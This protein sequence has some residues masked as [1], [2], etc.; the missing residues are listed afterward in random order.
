L[1]RE[2][3][4]NAF[5]KGF[6]GPFFPPLTEHLTKAW[7]DIN[8]VS[9]SLGTARR[10]L[11][12]IG[13]SIPGFQSRLEIDGKDGKGNFVTRWNDALLFT[14]GK[15]EVIIA[16]HWPKTVGE[17][18]VNRTEIPEAGVAVYKL[19][20]GNEVKQAIV[21]ECVAIYTK[22]EVSDSD[23][24]LIIERL[25]LRLTIFWKARMVPYLRKIF[26]PRP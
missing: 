9:K 19:A 13:R 1:E 20:E 5:V 15:G 6:D 14:Y 16:F 7:E 18:K 4:R 21:E 11:E 26:G 3:L 2:K 25:L 10:V 17:S 8:N 23:I 22:G 12:K 24:E